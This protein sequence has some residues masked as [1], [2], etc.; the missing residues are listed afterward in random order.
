MLK[1]TSAEIMP[2]PPPPNT[3]YS[4]IYIFSLYFRI[5]T[6]SVPED[7]DYCLQFRYSLHGFHVNELRVLLTSKHADVILVTLKH[8]FMSVGSTEWLDKSL[9]VHMHAKSK[10]R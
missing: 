3:Y 7:N 8:K 2:P 5:Y 9:M 6:P 1:H 4:V 10:V